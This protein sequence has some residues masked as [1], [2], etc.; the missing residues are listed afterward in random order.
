MADSGIMERSIEQT[1]TA[2]RLSRR[3]ICVVIPTYNNGR[4]IAGVVGA[5]MMQCDDVFVV[6]DGCTDDTVMQL[7]NMVRRPYIVVLE[8]N[9]GKGAALREGFRAALAQGFSYA[10]T[11]DGD[12]QHY[13]E[14]I[15]V[16]LDANIENPGALIVGQRMNLKDADR[17]K[18]S[19]FANRFSN[20]WFALQTARYLEDTQTGYRLYPLK[21]LVGL[22]ILTSRYE[23]ELELMVM[24]SWNGVPLVSVPVNVYYPPREQRVSHF[25]PARDFTRISIL[26]TVLCMLAVLYGYPRMILRKLSTFFRSSYALLVYLTGI[27]MYLIP[28][29]F[30]V[31]HSRL[32]EKEKRSRIHRL[33]WNLSHFIMMKHGIPGA[34]YSMDNPH[35]E[36][37]SKPAVVICNHQ[38]V[39]D[40]MPLLSLSPKIVVLTSDW[41]WNSPYFGYPIRKAG[42]MQASR[43]I[44]QLMPQ[45]R[46]MVDEGYNVAIYPEGTR[47]MNGKT[48]RF[49][50]G[51]FHV[52]AEL[53]LDV[54]PLTLYGSGRVMRKGGRKLNRWPMHLE[55]G[56]RLSPQELRSLGETSITQASAMRRIYN[57]NYSRIA[58]QIEKNV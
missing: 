9:S 40:L 58:D 35:G 30:L 10:I 50:Q 15:P 46:K 20:F 36:D 1:Q 51:A 3:G 8:K 42:Y 19:K 11:L 39:L 34:R 23:A 4:T 16:L 18:G 41:V 44:E 45:I 43:G 28:G 22:N 48:G 14:D 24:A 26:N 32:D 54:I 37:F 52:A 57:E 7:E 29:S 6:C 17:S 47:S 21:K 27:Y 53:G 25:R 49:H 55:V 31:M 12:G 13:P 33:L 5:A 38:S 56:R 2:S